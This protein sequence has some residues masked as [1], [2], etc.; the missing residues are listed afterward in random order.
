[1]IWN[2][3]TDMRRAIISRLRPA[4]SRERAARM[5]QSDAKSASGSLD[6]ITAIAGNVI[7]RD[8]RVE[9]TLTV[10][11]VHAASFP[12]SA[13]TLA[14]SGVLERFYLSQLSSPHRPI[15]L[16]AFIGVQCVGV[17]VGGNVRRA[18]TVFLRRHKGAVICAMLRR[19]WLPFHPAIRRRLKG[20]VRAFSKRLDVTS[21][22]QPGAPDSGGYRFSIMSIGVSPSVWGRGVGQLLMAEAERR[23]RVDGVKNL[24]LTVRPDN[25]R[26]VSFYERLG[27]TRTFKAGAWNGAMTKRLDPS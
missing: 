25:Y 7:I 5:S 8:V 26:A 16:G 6:A 1:V 15:V 13:L 4:V 21:G 9:D 2:G 17:L 11:R 20:G 24:F 10:S 3:H 27:W 18:M 14:G 19:P 12:T 22:S 23:A